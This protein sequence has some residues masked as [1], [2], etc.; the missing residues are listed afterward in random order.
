MVA[1]DPFHP[2]PRDIMT[3]P[4]PALR[5]LSQT[6]GP[7]LASALRQ[8]PIPPAL[9]MAI[10]WQET[11][12]LWGPCIGKRPPE[13]ILALCVGDTL[14]A[15]QRSAFPRSRAE[16]EAWPQGAEMFKQAR[17]A[18]LK[19]GQTHP[20]YARVARNPDKFCHGFGLFQRDI[21]AFKTHPAYFLEQSWA[22]FEGTANMAVSVL[23]SKLRVLY[24][25][26][27][28]KLSTSECI[29]LAI[30]YNQGHANTALG[31]R[32]RFKQGFK[33]SSGVYYGEHIA[34]VLPLAE[35]IWA[36]R[37]IT[38]REVPRR[39]PEIKSFRPAAPWPSAAWSGPGN[40]AA[41][42]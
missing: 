36:E 4:E 15:P 28:T 19:L 24:G 30:A 33:D 39:A 37:S 34:A 12:L 42:G 23:Q 3:K 29:Y 31:P 18:L 1:P 11:G 7:A 16:L 25:P 10:A 2:H 35:K 20:A 9:L 27:K 8:T 22:T 5:W 14:D 32:Q 26:G 38:A 13:E 6:F 40:L 17:A 41:C 21:Q